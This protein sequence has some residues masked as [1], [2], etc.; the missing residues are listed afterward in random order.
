MKILFISNF[1][2]DDEINKIY[3]KLK[4]YDVISYKYKNELET[5][6]ILKRNKFDVVFYASKKKNILNIKRIIPHSMLVLVLKNISIQ[7]T[8]K[9]SL[10]YKANLTIVFGESISVS[11]PLGVNWYEGHNTQECVQK[12]MNRIEYLNRITRQ[13]TT[14]SDNNLMLNWYF[15]RFK[16]T[17]YKSNEIVKV[18]AEDRFLKMVTDY[19]NVFRKLMINIQTEK[20]DTRLFR[21]TKGMPS[22]RKGKFI[23][24]SKRVVMNDYITYNDLV[25]VYKENDKLYY[26]G[27]DKPSVDTPIHM[28][29]YENLPNINYAIHSH[30]YIKGAVSTK[31]SIPCG[32]IEEAEEILNTIKE[33]YKSF[34]ERK[35]V[36]NELGHGS[37]I[38]GN[39]IDDLKGINY[40]KRPIPEY[41]D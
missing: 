25:A 30:N 21:C 31:Y 7:E 37:I 29:L 33:N 5:E 16:Q 1:I 18:P 3:N 14:K 15:D 9:Y 24:V 35:Y 2:D 26:C 32:A 11:D 17:E 12:V 39:S 23:Y 34:D 6:R 8:I 38:L 13:K 19:S 27:N 22:F 4:D 20:G 28:K 36:I 40:I 10:Q 41:I